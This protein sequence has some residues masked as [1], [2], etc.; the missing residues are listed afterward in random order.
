MVVK[1]V[2]DVEETGMIVSTSIL[3]ANPPVEVTTP[4]VDTYTYTIDY[5]TNL[6]RLPSPVPQILVLEIKHATYLFV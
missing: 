4:T 1:M 2:D 3:E 5:R 6:V